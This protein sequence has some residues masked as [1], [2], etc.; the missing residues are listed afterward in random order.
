MKYLFFVGIY[1]IVAQAQDVHHTQKIS[2]P[3][4]IPQSKSRRTS[5]DNSP[6]Y[7]QFSASPGISS[8]IS[9][10]ATILN[11][12]LHYQEDNSPRLH[13]SEH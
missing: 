7:V 1:V 9:A 3:L 2:A 12:L 8:I 11:P 10:A 13:A 5:L 4:Q 6:H